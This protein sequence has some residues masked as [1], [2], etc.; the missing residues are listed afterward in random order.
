M[1]DRKL[2]VCGISSAAQTR[3]ESRARQQ[4]AQSGILDSDIGSVEQIATEPS[5]QDL[6]L[7][8]RGAY[9]E[10]MSDELDELAN[11]SAI[12]EVPYFAVGTSTPADGY[13]TISDARSGRSDPRADVLTSF[14]GTLSRKGTRSSHRRELSTAPSQ[15]DHPFG[16]DQTAYV[17]VPVTASKVR[18]YNTD[19]H[20]TDEPT[21]VETRS[22]E[23]GDVEI[24]DAQAAPYD[25]PSLV[26][27]IAYDDEGPVDVRVWDE[28]G[29]GSKEDADGVLQWQKCFVASHDFAGEAILDNGLVR[30]RFDEATPA[31]SVERWDDVNSTWASQALGT[32]DWEFYDLDVR[33]V[34]LASVHA[35]VEFRDPVQSPTAYYTLNCWVKRG[36][37]D[38]LWGE[39]DG[40]GGTPLG[41]VDLLDPV[42][43]TMVYEPGES[44]GLVDRGEL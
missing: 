27:A 5:D 8:F 40:E 38:P 12:E 2:Y 4:I 11:A 26:Y 1:T 20:A 7:E 21:L 44:K 39:I 30:L 6:V 19:T 16:N 35:R 22:A 17:G 9:A 41:L 28:R 10:L 33:E 15:E 36:W 37:N 24:Y 31:L 34:G 14:D 13:Y 25:A 29:V 3:G 23:L 42:A 32:S 43:A 18:W